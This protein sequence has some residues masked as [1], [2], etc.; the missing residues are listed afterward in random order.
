MQQTMRRERFFRMDGAA[1]LA[2]LADSPVV[3]L[4]STDAEGR[5]LLRTLHSVVLDGAL[6]FHAAP[7]GEKAEIVGRPAVVAAEEIVATVPSYFS[8]AERACP[9]TTLY[10]S[11]QAHGVVAAVDSRAKKAQ[12]LQAL[13][14]KYQPEGRHVPIDAAHPRFEELYG[15]QV[16]AI[17]IGRLPLDRV[18]GKSKLAQNRSPAERAL[19]CEHLW[20]R[21]RDGDARAI[22][23]I[24][25]ANPDMPTP[26]FLR[27]EPRFDSADREPS[28]PIV[29]ENGAQ[30]RSETLADQLEPRFENSNTRSKAV[31]LHCALDERDVDAAVALLAPEYWNVARH[32]RARIAGALVG[33][34]AWVG[35][36][37]GGGRLVACARAISDGHKSAWIYD[38]IVA[39]DWRGCGLGQAVMQLLL[40]HPRLRTVATLFLQTRDAQPLYRK[41]G[42]LAADQVPPPPFPRTDMLR[43]QR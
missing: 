16:D 38:V 14:R 9:A 40:T 41:L 29:R 8:D 19:L 22:E 1:A 34:Q 23:L 18:D 12:V 28:L 35:A 15:K 4:A 5:P 37:D 7:V 21:G 20:A 32:S 39:P 13:M 31:T 17:W 10:R 3:H 11:A 24:R 30:T 26:A 2:L 6:H 42:F 27:F 36:R 43:N 25:A 33:A